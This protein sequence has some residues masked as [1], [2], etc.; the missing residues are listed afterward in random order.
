MEELKV[1]KT[2]VLNLMMAYNE[3]LKKL[4]DLENIL[5]KSKGYFAYNNENLVEYENHLYN[6]SKEVLKILL[7]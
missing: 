2:T 7:D 5:L 1:N 6:L 3:Y 4:K